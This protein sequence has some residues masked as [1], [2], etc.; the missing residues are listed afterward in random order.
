MSHFRIS[1]NSIPENGF[2]ATIKA[3][4]ERMFVIVLK[5]DGTSLDY[6]VYGSEPTHM[7]FMGMKR[8][9]GLMEIIS[10]IRSD[11][12]TSSNQSERVAQDFCFDKDA[13]TAEG[14]VVDVKIDG[15]T[16]F[17]I[18]VERDET[19]LR[20]AIRD[21]GGEIDRNWHYDLFHKFFEEVANV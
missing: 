7:P 2:V 3:G 20:F 8:W 19:A 11:Y 1:K 18:L 5:Q 10:D 15:F 9:D 17:N 14:T 6:T 12:F 4:N 21:V 13:I 16:L